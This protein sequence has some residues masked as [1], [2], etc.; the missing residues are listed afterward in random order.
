VF[1]NASDVFEVLLEP[2]AARTAPDAAMMP[3]ERNMARRL[4]L[5]DVEFVMMSIP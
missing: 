1:T 3:V 5:C 2:Q 4:M